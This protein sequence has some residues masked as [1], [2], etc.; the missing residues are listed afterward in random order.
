MDIN[1][2][3]IKLVIIRFATWNWYLDIM[4]HMSIFDID[5]WHCQWHVNIGTKGPA[6]PLSCWQQQ[7]ASS[8]SGWSAAS[9]WMYVFFQ[10]RFAQPSY[11]FSKLMLVSPKPLAILSL[12]LSLNTIAMPWRS[13][14]PPAWKEAPRN[15]WL[16]TIGFYSII[17]IN[18][19]S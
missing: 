8:S 4:V 16:S 1:I 19:F 2:N 17:N 9:L 15:E 5:H 11:Q 6:P 14:L 18:N 7:F 12:L 3:N 13:S 10:H